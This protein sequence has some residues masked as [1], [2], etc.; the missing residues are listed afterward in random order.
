[1]AEAPWKLTTLSPEEEIKFQQ[2][3]VSSPFYQQ[4]IA[5]YGQPPN[6]N[7]PQYD[8]RRAW[9]EGVYP[10]ISKH[11]NK[12]HWASKA[13]SGAWLKSPDHPTHWMEEYMQMTGK[14]PDSVN[15]DIYKNR[16]KTKPQSPLN[17]DI[18]EFL[19]KLK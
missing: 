18:G 13:P 15:E 19:E 9:K 12:Y 11:D 10:S 2:E 7:D 1:M 3:F 4:F 6:V 14:D 8:Y 5:N 17:L 16:K